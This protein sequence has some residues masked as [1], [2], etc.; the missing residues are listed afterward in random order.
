MQLI[1]RFEELV[2]RLFAEG[3]VPGDVHLSI[4]QEAV[5]VGVCSQ[6]GDRDW[7]ATSHRAHGVA[8]ARGV[9]VQPL[10]AELMGRVTG[11]CR[12]RAGS[13]HIACA[14]AGFLGA[15]PVIGAAPPLVAGAALTAKFAKSAAFRT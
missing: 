4:G 9:P 13:M 2:A 3:A 8:L 12:G 10:L 1:R 14:E 6:L 7:V 15:F 11:L 5:A